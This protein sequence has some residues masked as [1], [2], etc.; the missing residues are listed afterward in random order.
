MSSRKYHNR[1]TGGKGFG[2]PKEGYDM[3][4]DPNLIESNQIKYSREEV[5]AFDLNI[6]HTVIEWR[7]FFYAT[8]PERYNFHRSCGFNIVVCNN[9][10]IKASNM[11]IGRKAR[12]G[13]LKGD[14]K[15]VEYYKTME[16]V[17]D[18]DDG[19]CSMDVITYV[20]T[21][22]IDNYHRYFVGNKPP[23]EFITSYLEASGQVRGVCKVGTPEIGYVTTVFKFPYDDMSA[24]NLGNI[25]G[26]SSSINVEVSDSELEDLIKMLSTCEEMPVLVGGTIVNKPNDL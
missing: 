11:Y 1:K 8:S 25:G 17:D 22:M 5:L 12:K 10:D 20:C 3:L 21:S 16:D 4:K 15:L 19:Q 14:E 2:K 18:V 9:E 23:L 24:I 7:R 13:L 6:P 26:Y